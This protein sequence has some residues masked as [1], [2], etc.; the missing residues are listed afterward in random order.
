LHEPQAYDGRD[1]DGSHTDPSQRH[2]DEG[3]IELPN[4]GRR[5]EHRHGRRKRCNSEQD[6]PLRAQ[7]V[8]E[9]AGEGRQDVADQEGQRTGPRDQLGWPAIQALQ[10]DQVDALPVKGK[11][12]QKQ[13]HEET[14]K[15]G[16]PACITR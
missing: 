1:H 10:L 15:H 6:E 14:G 9:L 3:G 7:P 12:E 2:Q 13:R 4:R 5:R 16:A 8:H 11:A